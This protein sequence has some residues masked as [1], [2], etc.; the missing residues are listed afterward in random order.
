MNTTLQSLNARIRLMRPSHWV[1]NAFIFAP[2]VYGK[3]LMNTES[4]LRAV[5]AF[6]A[7]CFVSSSVYILNDIVD[8][9]A[10]SQHPKKKHRPIASGAV[11]VGSAVVQ[12]GLVAAVAVA[13][14]S[15]LPWQAGACIAIYAVLNL[16]YSFGLKH[17]VLLDIFII[18]AGFM[19][20]VLTGAKAIQVDV[21]EWLIICTLFLSLFLGVAK[22]RSELAHLGRGDSR[23]VLEDY[24]P[25]LIR[26]ILNVSVAGSIMSYTLY[27]VSDHTQQFFG[28]DKFVYTVPIVMYGIFRY[29]YLDEKRRTAENPVAVILRDPSLIATGIIWTLVSVAL[30]YWGR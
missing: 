21:S 24:T 25:E 20:R 22:R 11:S 4:D 9:N 3:A 14:A 8:R 10:D 18:A 26:V 23:K 5:M 15:Q 17:V 12:L 19:L 7:F 16:G 27:S 13:L 2:L 29:L 28:T 30:I 6:F 1:K